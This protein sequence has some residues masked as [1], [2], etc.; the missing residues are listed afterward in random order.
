VGGEDFEGI[1][2]TDGGMEAVGKQ[3]FR[4]H[5]SDA[6]SGRGKQCRIVKERRQWPLE[7]FAGSLAAL[8]KGRWPG[9]MAAVTFCQGLVAG[10]GQSGQALCKTAGVTSAA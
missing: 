6:F 3:N 7:S 5:G 1:N 9:A 10:T 8:I 2:G 4:I